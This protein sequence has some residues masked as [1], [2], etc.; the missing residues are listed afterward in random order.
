MFMHWIGA[1]PV[2]GTLPDI[3]G[4]TQDTLTQGFA[5]VKHVGCITLKLLWYFPGETPYRR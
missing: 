1:L 4:H 3:P 5:I 2:F